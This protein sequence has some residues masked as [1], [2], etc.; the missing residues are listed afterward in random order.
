[1][2]LVHKS[3]FKISLAFFL[4]FVE[5]RKLNIDLA[6][7]GVE[8][9]SGLSVRQHDVPSELSFVPVIVWPVLLV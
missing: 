3:T 4:L 9:L 6:E 8:Y 7:L 5:S 2:L 1:M